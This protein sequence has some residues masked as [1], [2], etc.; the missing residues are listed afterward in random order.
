MNLA[1]FCSVKTLAS[2][3]ELPL[4]TITVA[5]YTFACSHHA[6]FQGKLVY[7]NYGSEQ[8]FKDLEKIGVELN[9]TI[10]LTRYG[11]GVGR[12]EKA[13]NAEKYGVKGVLV[14]SDPDDFVVEGEVG[15]KNLLLQK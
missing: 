2:D 13:R 8:N 5:H 4:E 6:F 9:G 7:A 14:Y 15:K 3:L 11:G 12:G 10:A 1:P